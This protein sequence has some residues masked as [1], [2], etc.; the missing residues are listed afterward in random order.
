MVDLYHLARVAVRGEPGEKHVGI[1][2]V[3]L[4]LPDRFLLLGL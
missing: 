4:V 2:V 1:P 3:R